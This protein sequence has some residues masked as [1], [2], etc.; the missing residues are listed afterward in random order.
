MKRHVSGFPSAR[1][2]ICIWMVL[3]LCVSAAAVAEAPA[4]ALAEKLAAAEG[5][6]RVE[7]VE[8]NRSAWMPE[9]YIVTVEQQLDWKHPEAGSFPQRVELGLHPG[10]LVNVLETNGYQLFDDKLP[11]DD[12]PEV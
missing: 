9:K 12:Q 1:A 7:R 11:T 6:L 4:S 2:A 10:A 3:L 8:G 5:V